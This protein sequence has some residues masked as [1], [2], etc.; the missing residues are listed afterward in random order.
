M[1]GERIL[2]A[3]QQA[4][5]LRRGLAGEILPLD[6]VHHGAADGTSG[7]MCAVGIGVH[8]GLAALVHCVGDLVAD[9]DAAEGE[10][11][12][13]NGLGVLDHVGLDVPVL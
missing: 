3:D 8:P 2:E 12:R 13:G 11:A 4:L 7:G 10:V 6:Q 1:I 9:P 5:A